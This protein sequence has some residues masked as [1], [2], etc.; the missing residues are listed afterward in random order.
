MAIQHWMSFGTFAEQKY[1]IYPDKKTYFGII[2]NANMTSHA[3]A[4]LAGFLSEKADP[5][6]KYIIDPLTH[7]FQHDIL[8]ICSKKKDG[9]IEIKAPYKALATEYGNP[10]KEILGSRP[11]T[12]EDLYDDEVLY[13]F[14]T[15]VLNYQKKQLSIR[16]F[17]SDVNRKYLQQ[18]ETELQPYALIA[19]YF[20]MTEVTY[21]EWLPLM[22]KAIKHAKVNEE[23]TNC[24]IFGSIVISQGIVMDSDII[25]EIV[26]SFQDCG[27]DGYLF[28]VDGLNEQSAGRKELNG[29]LELAKGLRNGNREVINLHGGYFSLIASGGQFREQ[30]YTGVAHGAEFGESRTVVPVGGG[31]PIAKYYMRLLHKRVKYSEAIFFLK[32]KGWLDSSELFHANVCDCRECRETLNGNPDNFVL[33]GISDTKPVR[34]GSTFI[35]IDYPTQE[36]KERCLKHFLESKKVEYEFAEAATGEEIISNLRKGF[37]LFKGTT[38]K[39]YIA[40]LAIWAKLFANIDFE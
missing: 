24:K 1:Y 11:I 3:P 4:G 35:N 38:G 30:C 34:R 21:K 31:I 8:T 15:N 7:A 12:S 2:F 33:Y 20:F 40:Y 39:D 27:A 28:W 16:I 37:E 36:T 26:N 6:T 9:N 19:P 5:S 29:V 17:E 32:S 18:N 10:V 23:F 13:E 14:S 25:E 22:V